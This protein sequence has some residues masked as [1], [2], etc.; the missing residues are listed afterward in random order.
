MTNKY[1]ESS[2]VTLGYREAIKQSIGMYIGSNDLS[3]MHHLL[4]EIVSNSMDEAAAGYGK[5]IKVTI[6]RSDNSASVEDNGRGIPFHKKDNG[7]YA[8]IEMCTNL[9]SGG[10]FEGQG[11][12]KSSLGL[13]GVGATVTNALSS[14]FIIEVWRD[15]EH[16]YFE[17]YDGDVNDPEITKYSG[18][19]QGT[20]ITFIPDK[21][22]FG[23][24]KWDIVK[25]QEELQLHALLNNGITFE[26]VEKD[27][28]KVLGSWKYY[29]T[30]G[31]KDMLKIKSADEKL[32]TN[33]IYFS[34]NVAADTGETCLVEMAFAYCEKGSEQI[35]SFVNGGYTPNDGTHVTGWKT[36][37]TSLINK[38]A[39]DNEV[40]KEKDKNLSGEIIRKGL[41][42]ILSIKM[43]CRPMFAEQTKKT[44]NSPV[45]RTFCSRAVAQL[46][47][48]PKEIKSI[49]DKIMIEQ[50]AEEAAQ[51]K[52]E[53]Q[54][55]IA[56]GGK[57][58]NSLKDLPEK[59]A[60]ANDFTDAEIF[61]CEGLSAAGGAKEMKNPSQA[62]LPLRG[63]VLNTTSKELA[64][65]IKSDV[66]KDILTCLG[67]GIGDH[68]NI[69]N[70]RYNRIIIFTDADPDGQHIEL[71]LM[72]LFLHHLP[73]LVRAGKIY[74]AISPLYKTVNGKEI[75]YWTPDQTSEY[76][77]YMRNHKNAESTR[78]KGLGEL[79]AKELYET[80]MDPDNR[81]LIQ[82]TTDDMEKTLKLYEQL[83]GKQPSLRKDF[84]IKNKLSKYSN[85][86]DDVFDDDDVDDI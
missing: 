74:T 39:R 2:I 44:L 17:V 8:I 55:K 32:L 82:L 50:K 15:G 49:L 7:E 66:I 60:D 33:P 20:T 10:K 9:H 80:S 31:I 46:Q 52:R 4:T 70:L 51:R 25:I 86:D 72:T 47:L 71:L 57:S 43:D 79:N 78:I 77:K 75:K 36:A 53:A 1:D 65:I 84:I 67:C 83:M 34:T 35:Y 37:Y 41:I 38:L 13:H 30:N 21:N 28:D 16:C 24:A 73:E 62:V 12:Y 54:E 56:R 26:L 5:T 11:N 63:K 6:N 22:V 69:N 59:L 19:R 81:T 23:N 29:Y 27:D 85:L 18:K 58:M 40:L 76:K 68:F 48:Q 64:D 45:A 42:L 14:D 3:G 61:F